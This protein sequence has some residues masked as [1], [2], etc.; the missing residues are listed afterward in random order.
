MKYDAKLLIWGCG[1]I[2]IAGGSWW[3]LHSA[4]AAI[5]G[6]E[7]SMSELNATLDAQGVTIKVHESNPQAHDDQRIRKLETQQNRI[8]D[9]VKSLMINQNAIC[10]ATNA[11]CK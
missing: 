2:F 6:L 1:I 5:G 7:H 11:R 10:Q 4:T 9:D 8:G 3:S